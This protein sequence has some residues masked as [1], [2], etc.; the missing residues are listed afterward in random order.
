MLKRGFWMR[1]RPIGDRVDR[2]ERQWRR[3]GGPH[4]TIGGVKLIVEIPQFGLTRRFPGSVPLPEKTDDCGHRRSRMRGAGPDAQKT[5]SC[6]S[7][8]PARS[9]TGL[10]SFED[11]LAQDVIEI[12]T[13]FSARLYGSRGHETKGALQRTDRE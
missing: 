9:K 13:V 11:E 7:A 12:I 8:R 2:G 5:G 4:M 10:S 3:I 1:A 6:A